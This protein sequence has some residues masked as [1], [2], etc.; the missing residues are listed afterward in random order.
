MTERTNKDI[1]DMLLKPDNDAVV[2]KVPM[3]RFGFDFEVKA[4][5]N[6]QFERIT[7]RATRPGPKGQKTLDDNLFNYMAIVE[8]CVVPNWKDK[9]LIK[10]LGAIDAVDAVKKR[11]LFSEVMTLLEAIGELN[12]FGKSDQELIDEVKN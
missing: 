1:L 12:D 7:Q 6:E 8:A 9:E 2:T 11:L 3:P 10:A 4:L 5:T